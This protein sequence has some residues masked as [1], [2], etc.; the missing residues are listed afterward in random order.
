VELRG[1]VPAS[2]LRTLRNRARHNRRS[3]QKEITSI[4]EEAALDRASLAQQIRTTHSR[5]D[6][7]MTLSELHEAIEEGRA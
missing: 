3:M 2:V 5:L 7:K 1:N 6:A 4:L